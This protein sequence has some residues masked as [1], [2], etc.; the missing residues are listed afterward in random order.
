MQTVASDL[1]I[2]SL[3]VAAFHLVHI[4][5]TPTVF[6]PAQRLQI[7][8]R[9]LCDK[10]KS[11]VYFSFSIRKFLTIKLL[12]QVPHFLSCMLQRGKN[13]VVR[14]EAARSFG[15]NC[16]CGWEQER[17]AKAFARRPFCPKFAPRND[18]GSL[19][20]ERLGEDGSGNLPLA[21]AL[22]RFERSATGRCDAGVSAPARAALR[23][24]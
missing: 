5:F 2:N 21:A 6:I 22:D 12:R 9:M 4:L 14:R 8:N 18:E 10:K 24:L 15:R 11:E 13:P 3:P 23:G 1:F 17:G 7:R 19:E 16:S 20:K